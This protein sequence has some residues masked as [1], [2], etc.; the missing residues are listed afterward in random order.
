MSERWQRALR[1][2]QLLAVDPWGLGGAVVRAAPG[3]VRD[4]WCRQL[5]ALLPAEVPVRRVPLHITED[6]LLGGLDL[7]GTLRSGRPVVQ[8]GLL[9]EADG[10][11]LFVPMAER[12]PGFSVA[13]LGAVL[14][15]QEVVL[16]RDGL[17]ERMPAR[18]A[19]VALDEGI[20][21]QRVAPSLTD[22]LGIYLDLEGIPAAAAAPGRA[23]R[24]GDGLDEVRLSAEPIRTARERLAQVQVSDEQV[25]A[26]CGLALALG[27]DS[28]R[29]PTLA[30]RLARASAALEGRDAVWDDDAAWAA[31]LVLGPRATRLPAAEAPEEP[32]EPEEPGP[33]E[34]PP[35]PDGAESEPE[36]PDLD[37]LPLEDLMIAAARAAMPQ[38]LLAALQVG[39]AA[40]SAARTSG[41]SGA[42]QKSNQR[43]RPVGVRP[44]DPRIDGRLDVLETLRA[45]APWQR[46]RGGRPGR[47]QVRSADF[48]I[49]RTQRRTETLTVFVVD[50]SGSAAL[51]RLAEAKGAVEQVLAD[52]YV[53]RDHVALIAFRG[54]GAD[55]ILP[56]TR[57][58]VRAKKT[59]AGLPGGGATPLAAGLDAAVTLALDARRR[60]QTPVL[61]VM[62]DGRANV[63]RDGTRD[64]ARAADD[65]LAGARQAAENGIA[66]LFVDT[67]PRPQPAARRLAE[68]MNAYYL[69]LPYT[70]AEGISRMVQTVG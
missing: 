47:V 13:H 23:A 62:T 61:V 10:G 35:E 28:M 60:G 64:R 5:R 46:L 36:R 68:A 18:V 33:P 3:P 52:C 53:R 49:T 22:R 58:L 11:V 30:L 50:A 14:D 34:P 32:D 66:S 20:E 48:R 37:D 6:R 38:G 24:L 7:V 25:N 2:A 29:A 42:V 55:L 26:V 15:R 12:L 69:A 31:Q 57:S 9:S 59:L 70:G 43:G 16:E 40:R 39:W 67:A 41:V 1:A 19:V 63:A 51:Q 21:D 56:P 17:T 44:G 54:E 4:V 65:A 45:A 27:V 8:R